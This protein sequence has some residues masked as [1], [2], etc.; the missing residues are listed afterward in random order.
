MSETLSLAFAFAW[1][2]SVPA[3]HSQEVPPDVLVKSVSSEVI[4]EIRRDKALQAGKPA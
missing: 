2:F 1:L 4:A 3:A